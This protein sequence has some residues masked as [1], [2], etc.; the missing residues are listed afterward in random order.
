VSSGS[1]VKSLQSLCEDFKQDIVDGPF[2]SELKRTDYLKH[3]IPV[4]KIQNIK[5]FA[6]ERKKMDFVSPAKFRELRRHSYRRGDIVMTKLGSPLG[7]SA[8]V[9]DSDEGVIVADLVRIRAQRINTKYL[10]Y[11]L[12]SQ[13]TSDF[14]NAMQK[15]TTRPRVTLSVVRELPIVVPSPS[16]Q[17]RIVG[18][19]DEAFERIATAKAKAEQ[20]LQNARALFES[21]LHSVF[22]QHGSGWVETRLDKISTNLDSK[23]V[24]ITKNVRSR[25]EYPYYGASGIVDYVA[26]YI[27]DGDALL[28]SEDGAN[29]LA[30]STPIAFSVSGKYWVNNHAHILKFDQM[31]T[32]RFVEFYLESIKLDDYITGAAQPKLNQTALNSIPIPIPTSVEVQARIV[33]NIESLYEITR[34]LAALYEQKLAALEMLKQSLLHQAFA[35]AL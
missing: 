27:F 29:L 30:R 24:P 17:H 32:Q 31:A 2:G 18:I 11:H 10:C 26:D 16:E 13:L 12:N 6:I 28:V 34:R 22:N 7:V 23:R 33:R 9:E 5:P 15:G 8:I 19:L 20:N 25:G 1:P 21:H 14:I 4:L 35:G 3:G